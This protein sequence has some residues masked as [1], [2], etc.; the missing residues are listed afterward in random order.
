MRA[1]TIVAALVAV[2]LIVVALTMMRDV[3]PGSEAEAATDD[4][5][6]ARDEL[7]DPE[8]SPVA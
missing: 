5:T 6:E 2:A 7:R 1:S 8:T 4:R 3:R